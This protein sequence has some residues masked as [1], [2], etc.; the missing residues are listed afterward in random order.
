[1]RLRRRRHAAAHAA[2]TIEHLADARHTLAEASEILA[3]LI[4]AAAQILQ[5]FLRI[6]DDRICSQV[7]I[8]TIF[9][10]HSS[11]LGIEPGC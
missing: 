2:W 8:T 6:I 11:L 3:E 7:L 9:L 1:M 10:A 4:D 5:A